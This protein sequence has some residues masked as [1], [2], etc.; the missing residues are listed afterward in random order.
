LSKRKIRDYLKIP[1]FQKLHEHGK[2]IAERIGHQVAPDSFN[3]VLTEFYQVVGFLPEAIVNYLFLLGWSLDDKTEDFTREEMIHHFSLDRVN[4]SPASFDPAKLMA[5]Q[6][7]Y[8]QRVPLKQK[9]AMMLPF[10][11]RAGLVSDPAPCAIGPQLLRIAEAA[12][13]RIRV[14]GDILQYDDLFVADEQLVVDDKAFQK[15]VSAP[16]IP[17]LLDRFGKQLQHVEPFTAANLDANLHRFLQAE[18]IKIGQIIHAIRVAVT[19]KAVGF[20]LFETMEI[21][22]RERCLKRIDRAIQKATA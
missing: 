5:F 21:L 1:E 15:R 17:G 13:D 22:G 18:G 2:S 11:Q 10:L 20:G 3:P 19:G 6:E 8:M 9:P 16:G 7:R 14:A 12:A 4:R